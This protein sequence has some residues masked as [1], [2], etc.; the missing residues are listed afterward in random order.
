MD[1]VSGELSF[2]SLTHHERNIGHRQGRPGELLLDNSHPHDPW[3][4]PART[5][6]ELIN[7]PGLRVTRR[8]E[9]PEIYLLH[10][11]APARALYA[12]AEAERDDPFRPDSH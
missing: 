2:S 6:E 7:E 4:G 9:I 11:P 8:A 10:G 1:R 3:L 5:A 12:S